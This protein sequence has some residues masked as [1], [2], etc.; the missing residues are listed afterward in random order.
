MNIKRL[1]RFFFVASLILMG[2]G[3]L[4]QIGVDSPYSR[5]GIG[6]IENN[7]TIARFKAMGGVSVAMSGNR[8]I[9]PSNPASYAAF[10]S[11][12]FLFNAGL[13]ASS[14]TYR[15][16]TQTEQG[17]HATLSYITLGFPVTRWWRS[18]TG[19]LPYSQ[20]GYSIQVPFENEQTGR[21]NKVFEGD[22]G[23]NQLYFGNAFKLHKDFSVGVNL[24][25]IFGRSTNSLLIYSPD[26]NYFAN[27]KVENRLQA[28]DF[29]VDYGLL[30]RKNL[31]N[32]MSLQLGLTYN[33]QVNLGVK[34]EY[35]VRS[36]FGGVN[37]GVEYVLDTIDYRPAEKGQI[38]LP[39]GAGFGFMLEKQNR[40]LVA[41][42]INWRNWENFKAFGKSDSLVN[43]MNIALGG[44]FT[45]NHTS[46]SGYWKRVSYRMGARYEQ[47]YLQLFGKQINEFGISFGL[48][49][50][51]PRTLTTI[52]ISAEV[53]RRGTT[54]K[55][56]IQETFVNLTVGVSIYE[57]WFEKRRYN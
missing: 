23:L 35:L 57:R 1:S 53:G 13:N 24:S 12:S 14:V 45:P 3:L 30:Y 33:Q 26:S 15:T 17:S 9:N 25:Y 29:V 52:D 51:L 22:G 18:S 56:L 46:I 8:F 49:L 34:R 20:V 44:Q 55:N 36:I 4:A 37:G 42:D 50:P 54:E 27:T 32:K 40:W 6:Q 7:N 10:D 5:F 2:S 21:Y 16:T 11:L 41:M 38:S 39:A 48:G 28:N 19:L 47:T 31:G 43:S